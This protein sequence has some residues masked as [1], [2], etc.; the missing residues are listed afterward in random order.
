VTPNLAASFDLL[1]DYI[2]HPAFNPADLERVRTQQLTR[3][4]NE[5]NNPSAIAQRALL[6]ILYG[7][8]P[9]GIPPSGTGDA[10]V[11]EKLT[12]DDLAAFHDTWLRPDR[13]KVFVV[14]DTTLPEV[15]RLLTA[16][17][18]DWQ[19]PATPAPVKNFAVD[20]PAQTSRIILID[21]PASPQSI[22][23]AGRVLPQKGTDDLVVLNAANEVFGG[24]FL[25]RINTNLRET[26]GWSYG[27]NSLVRAPLDRTAFM[28]YAPVQADRTGDSIVEL[29]KDL[30]SYTSGKGVTAEELERLINGN[31]R[32]LPGRFETSSDVLGG[33]VDIVE[34][35]RPDDY[36]ETLSERYSALKAADLDA[37]ALADFKGSDLVY[38]VVGDAKVVQPQLARIGLPIEV[39]SAEQ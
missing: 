17:F 31:V 21:R 1:A 38:V 27:V 16:S 8:H 22:I 13:A 15:V 32:E 11:V 5:L 14:G 28:I 39:R 9:Y 36:Y 35:N 2:R 12:R 19:A 33:I 20:V 37:A 24:S 10:A 6:P 4:K 3:I 29:R 26:K 18:G 25:S 34:H 30:T 23:F 7:E